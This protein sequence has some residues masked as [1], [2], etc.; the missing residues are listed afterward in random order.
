MNNYMYD[1][2]YDYEQ[3]QNTQNVFESNQKSMILFLV[4]SHSSIQRSEQ[5]R[6]LDSEILPDL[7]AFQ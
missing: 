6:V 5:L 4:N 3:F 2:Y 7:R 1:E